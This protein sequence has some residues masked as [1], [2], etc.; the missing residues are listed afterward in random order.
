MWVLVY[1]KNLSNSSRNKM[2][3]KKIVCISEQ[4]FDERNFVKKRKN[5]ATKKFDKFKL[6]RNFSYTFKGSKSFLNSNS[7]E[8]LSSDLHLD[9]PTLLIIFSYIEQCQ[10]G[11]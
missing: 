11:C 6:K 1:A 10:F 7:F 3:A 2:Q 4:C 5:T 9:I 8:Y